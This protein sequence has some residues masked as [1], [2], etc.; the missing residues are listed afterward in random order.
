VFHRSVLA[1]ILRAD[2][3]GQLRLLGLVCASVLF[4]LL[5]VHGFRLLLDRAIPQRDERLLWQLGLGLLLVAL[6]KALVEYR[7]ALAAERLRA[8]LHAKLRAEL[9]AHVLRLP[10]EHFARHSVGQLTNRIQTEVG[11][12]G[13]SV[14]SVFVQPLVD[15]VT[16]VFY[17]GYLLSMSPLLT[18]VAS[19][20]LPLILLV[21]PRA[22]TRLAEASRRIGQNLGHYSAALQQSLSSAFEIQVHGTWRYE[23]ARLAHRQAK[24]A[25]DALDLVRYG[26]WLTLAV[27]LAR[28]CAP[29]GV[30]LY[31]GWLAMRGQMETGE[32]VAFAAVLG[33]LYGSLDKLARVPPMW[34]TAQDRFDELRE[35]LELPAY[36]VDAHGIA[37]LPEGD[38][39]G[40]TVTLQE[41]RFGYDKAR[42]IVDGLS[43]QIGAGERVAL[44]GRS[45][46]GKSTVLQLMCGR[47]R[48][49]SGEVCIDGASVDEIP[50]DQL[51]ARV[52]VVG[53]TP[54]LFAG[55]VRYNLVY[56]MLRAQRGDPADPLS[57]LALPG[58]DGQ[59]LDGL[60]LELCERVALSEDLLDL[61]LQ[62][63]LPAS[64]AGALLAV[65][66]SVRERVGREP[67]VAQ[68][69][70]GQWLAYAGVAENLLFAPDNDGRIDPEEL[71]LW[72][73]AACRAGLDELLAEIGLRAVEQDL[74]K[75][76]ALAASG[77]PGAVDQLKA[78]GS[79]PEDVAE[80]VAL[81]RRCEQRPI[82]R[83]QLDSG[84]LRALVRKGLLARDAPGH[85]EQIVA[86]RPR[87]RAALGVLAPAPY[88]PAL[89]NDR[90]S[91][92]D[93]LLF[94]HLDPEDGGAVARVRALL[95]EALAEAG[96]LAEVRRAGL[97]F[98]VGER[99]SRLSGG[100]RQKVA[101]A[102]VLLK[103]PRLVLLD[104]VTA[105]LDPA[106]ARAIAD[107]FAYRDPQCTVV[108][109][110]HQHGWAE[111]F[112]RVLVLEA[113]RV[114]R[115]CTPAELLASGG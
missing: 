36:F 77:Q 114:V 98:D 85:R 87:W 47:L 20:A 90:L 97:S 35:T 2:P 40:A 4:G 25:D 108:A 64:Q 54:T 70:P 49:L 92:R 15:L 5:P 103:R 13:M 73:E 76:R 31:G 78:M 41:V 38:P 14:P 96:L 83:D 23:E 71:A 3:Y 84:T 80:R 111:R 104:E 9:S 58:A 74:D 101:L 26:G 50:L 19:S 62:M 1:Y 51:T 93:N 48:P 30:Y 24:V 8:V 34:R 29:V 33:G 94:G 79:S 68:L 45:G 61:G 21:A 17:A 69:V 89:W 115:E 11:R 16:F 28:F 42:P 7:Q 55:T 46:C 65:R 72:T 86:A 56:A 113:G 67:G 88:D 60:L 12:L 95:H 106:S 66:L 100:Q 39:V 109:I 99:G 105:S 112:D 81:S 53:Q 91:V 82:S 18:A 6:A 107:V 75:L 10:P 52:G 63:K 37:P 27:D 110:T 102:R 57:Y 44:V 43:L 32:I 22:N 59:G